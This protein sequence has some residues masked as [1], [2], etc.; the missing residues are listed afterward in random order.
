MITDLASP[1]FIAGEA[2]LG[3]SLTVF[4]GALIATVENTY[5]SR[6]EL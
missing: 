6:R 1:M 2:L 5:S 4:V 3:L